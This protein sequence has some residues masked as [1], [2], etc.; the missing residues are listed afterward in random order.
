MLNV[1]N[2]SRSGLML[3]LVLLIGVKV[4][5]TDQFGQK[6]IIMKNDSTKENE[7]NRTTHLHNN[8][9][10]VIGH[11]SWNNKQQI[12]KIPMLNLTLATS[13]TSSSHLSSHSLR[14]QRTYRFNYNNDNRKHHKQWRNHNPHRYGRYRHS[15]KY[16]A[17]NLLSR[18]NYHSASRPSHYFENKSKL[19]VKLDNY[20]HRRSSVERHV[21]T[22]SF[23]S[24]ATFDH[25]E[26]TSQSS[27]LHDNYPNDI[28]I[29]DD[30]KLSDTYKRDNSLLIPTHINSMRIIRRDT[31]SLELRTI[32]N[33]QVSNF[34]WPNKRIA[35][36]DGDIMIG[37]LHMVH[38][39][40][41]Q[42]ICGP[43]M[44]QGGL[45]AAEV[46]LYT[47]DQINELQVIPGGLKLGAYIL[48]DCDTD[49]YG[50]QQAVDFIKGK[51][52]SSITSIFKV[53][54]ANIFI[55]RL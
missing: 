54:Y 44:P 48:D 26:A 16:Q 28:K 47:V 46:M 43:V 37:G 18:M 42:R 6:L 33:Q 55:I 51:K 52:D 13:L 4:N 49:T 21:V 20:R 19:Q 32:E 40:E 38:E 35:E 45:Q 14:D 12:N 29:Y 5:L 22:T 23:P 7:D 3:L 31:E 53:K 15:R 8:I 25:S 34:T 24:Y 41:N 30:K 17:N 10:S 27:L 39:R 9:I 1:D 50:L 36:I 11:T 2:N